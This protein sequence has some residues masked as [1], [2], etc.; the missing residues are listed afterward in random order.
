MSMMDKVDKRVVHWWDDSYQF[1]YATVN[2]Y[3]RKNRSFTLTYSTKR[4]V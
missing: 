1:N 3:L 2:G 4:N